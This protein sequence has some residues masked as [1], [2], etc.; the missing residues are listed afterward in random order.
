MV[1][2][3][4]LLGWAYSFDSW[5]GL[6]KLHA[7]MYA[8][9]FSLENF[10]SGWLNSLPLNPN[11]LQLPYL[12]RGARRRPDHGS[13]VKGSGIASRVAGGAVVTLP[14]RARRRGARRR[15]PA[16]ASPPPLPR[17]SSPPRRPSVSAR[18]VAWDVDDGSWL[19]GASPRRDSQRCRAITVQPVLICC[20]R[21]ENSKVPAKLA[22]SCK[23]LH[24]MTS[25]QPL[26]Q[27]LHLVPENPLSKRL[28]S[29]SSAVLCFSSILTC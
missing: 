8:T 11:D 16:G 3:L 19:H 5:V 27:S 9:H 28:R 23:T 13:S 10:Y 24:K 2:G 7:C 12:S 1:H 29:V 25:R 21:R 22:F 6:A 26:Y 4:A 17:R 20:L 15:R 14:R 18:A